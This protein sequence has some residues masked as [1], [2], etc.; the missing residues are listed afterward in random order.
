MELKRLT[1]TS[2]FCLSDVFASLVQR[3]RK[4]ILFSNPPQLLVSDK[5]IKFQ[6]IY[7]IQNLWDW[8]SFCPSFTGWNGE[9]SRIM[10]CKDLNIGTVYWTAVS[11]VNLYCGTFTLY[12]QLMHTCF[13]CSKS[14]TAYFAW[15]A[16]CSL[17]M[18]HGRSYYGKLIHT[19]LIYRSPCCKLLA[20]PELHP[21][22][23]FSTLL[24][25]SQT[26]GK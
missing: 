24:L 8:S 6:C 14:H 16:L 3:E 2:T 19:K 21:I 12:Q 15:T 5:M 1:L 26:T 25:K 4:H 9:V 23:F 13:H 20:S 17:Y 10:K 7:G 22:D 18:P 11:D